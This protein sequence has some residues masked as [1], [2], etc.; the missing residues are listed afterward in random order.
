MRIAVA[1]TPGLMREPA[2]HA[3]AVVDVLRASTSLVAMFDQGLLRAIVAGTLRDARS[4]AVQNFSL[5]CGEVEARPPRGFDH[6]NSPAEFASLSLKGRSAVLFTTNG[7]RALRSAR[8]AP[9]VVAAA[10]VNR[11]AASCRL[12]AE[13][14]RRKL[15]I[16]VVCAGSDGGQAF[17]LEDSIAAGAIV[18]AVHEA[19][20]TVMLGDS[21]WAVYHLWRWYRGDAMR[22]FRESAHGRAL[23]ALG[24][25]Q[26]LRFAARLD[27]SPCVPVLERDGQT[28]RAR[29][30]RADAR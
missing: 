18:E 2:E 1:L 22:A 25:G 21:A 11:R 10:L 14:A 8:A 24:F 23:L 7:T 17:S 16:A 15:D 26:D 4:L 5:L 20:E 13:A 6:G 9:L 12:L 27:A 30:A 19:D 28:L 29:R 3:V